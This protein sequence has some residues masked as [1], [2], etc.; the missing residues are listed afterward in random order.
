M[1]G[2]DKSTPSSQ[3]S[4]LARPITLN[5]SDDELENEEEYNHN[6]TSKDVEALQEIHE[7]EKFSSPSRISD[8]L[9]NSGYDLT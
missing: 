3:H 4:T 9:Y 1:K 5:F 6:D 8:S 7:Y 2:S